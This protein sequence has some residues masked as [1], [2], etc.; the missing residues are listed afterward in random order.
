MQSRSAPSNPF[1][2]ALGMLARRPYSIAEL[3]RSLKKK[4][5]AAD[6]AEVIARLRQLGYLDD[7]KIAEN[8]A[9]SLAQNRSYGR[10][11]VRRE[12]KNKLLDS[13]IVD[14]A[15]EKTF[16]SVNER[17]LLERVVDKKIRTLRKPLTR[18][19]LASLCQGLI[20][21]GFRADDIMR[22]VHARPE[23]RTVSEDVDLARMEEDRC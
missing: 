22:V 2:T 8:Y 19:K 3:R 1:Q 20:R 16:E 18:S 9:L 6:I 21:R 4:F 5:P 10:Y 7:Q 12:L 13:R 14:A 15:V 11:R 23:L 17:Q